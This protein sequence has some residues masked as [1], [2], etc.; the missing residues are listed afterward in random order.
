MTMTESGTK[1]LP[2][3]KYTTCIR[4]V[5]ITHV[6]YTIWYMT[7]PFFWE[8]YWSICKSNLYLRIVHKSQECQFS[9]YSPHVPTWSIK[10]Y[11][12]LIQAMNFTVN[13]AFTLLYYCS[14]ANLWTLMNSE[15]SFV[16]NI[17]QIQYKQIEQINNKLISLRM[18]IAHGI[19]TQ[20]TFRIPE[21]SSASEW[22]FR[23]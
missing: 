5:C 23:I 13:Y 2:Y 10:L 11:V 1:M 8:W 20:I 7:S 16:W 9:S 4:C 18:T 15:K 22:F 3:I 19:H 6:K 21:T 14:I 17:M 12:K